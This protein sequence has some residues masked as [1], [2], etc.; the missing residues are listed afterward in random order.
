MCWIMFQSFDVVCEVKKGDRIWGGGAI[1]AVRDKGKNLLC[2]SRCVGVVGWQVCVLLHYLVPGLA[3]HT[4][5]FSSVSG[6]QKTPQDQICLSGSLTCW[7]TMSSWSLYGMS[8]GSSRYTRTDRHIT[9]NFWEL[10]LSAD[11]WTSVHYGHALQSLFCKKPLKVFLFWPAGTEIE[12]I[13]N[14][15]G[16]AACS[17]MSPLPTLRRRF[18]G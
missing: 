12:E 10:I 3:T 17:K 1:A 5:L 6:F 11:W 7:L 9:W 2:G 14:K 4:L 16:Q 15:F 18:V 13:M 8:A